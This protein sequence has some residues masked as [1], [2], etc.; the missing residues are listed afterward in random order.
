MRF[1]A[2]WLLFAIA[3]V[4]GDTPTLVMSVQ[5]F[6]FADG[7]P[8]TPLSEENTIA[9]LP[10]GQAME[11]F[12]Q[13]KWRDLLPLEK[14]HSVELARKIIAAADE[15]LDR[16]ET[17]WDGPP[18]VGQTVRIFYDYEGSTIQHKRRPYIDDPRDIE[19]MAWLIKQ[20]KTRAAK[21][22]PGVKTHVSAYHLRRTLNYV[23]ARV[24]DEPGGGVDFFTDYT[25][26]YWKPVAGLV[27]L[28]ESEWW[29]AYPV[30]DAPPGNR[31]RT[32]EIVVA[33]ADWLMTNSIYP[34]EVC[35]VTW[36]FSDFDE[37]DA[38]DFF[39]GAKEGIA[40]VEKKYG[41]VP[42]EWKLVVA[43]DWNWLKSLVDVPIES[44]A[45]ADALGADLCERAFVTGWERI[46]E[47][48]YSRTFGVTR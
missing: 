29:H 18:E 42:W 39:E 43:G 9:W 5:N 7:Q 15:A 2:A 3:A 38:T 17:L 32:R 40:I 46:I 26:T 35:I 21:R 10:H 48:P 20:T 25:G 23:Q 36:L 24:G 12:Q 14:T 37:Q 11:L 33:F 8:D 27:E 44:R 31:R 22:W 34:E 41:A 19:M 45:E 47:G 16:C 28:S 4:A 30:S 1:I 13:E 6:P